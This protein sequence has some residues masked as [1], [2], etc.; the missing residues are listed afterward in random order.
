V[1]L[2]HRP[3]PYQECDLRSIFA[4]SSVWVVLVKVM[5]TFWS[6]VN[7]NHFNEKPTIQPSS[8]DIASGL[9]H[10]HRMQ[11]LGAVFAT[12]T[13]SLNPWHDTAAG[14]IPHSESTVS[15]LLKTK[16]IADSHVHVQ[17]WPRS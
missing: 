5:H 3:R 8:H 15:F 10:P 1:D 13:L 17:C 9:L 16:R 14:T 6:G 2:N 7:R 4:Q 12:L 11:E